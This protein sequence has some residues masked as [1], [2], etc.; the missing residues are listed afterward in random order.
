MFRCSEK[1]VILLCRIRIF[2]R[3]RIRFSWDPV[4]DQEPDPINLYPD[5]NCQLGTYG[6]GLFSIIGSR[7]GSGQFQ[8]GSET[9]WL[10]RSTTTLLISSHQENISLKYLKPLFSM[11]FMLDGSFE[12]VAYKV[13]EKFYRWILNL[14]IVIDTNNMP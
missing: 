6:S 1:N 10:A 7:F 9:L 4:K 12:Y 14:R 5:P 3:I 2:F 8:P 13:K 11:V